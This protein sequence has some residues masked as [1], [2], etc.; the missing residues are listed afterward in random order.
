MSRRLA[1]FAIPVVSLALLARRASPCS[2]TSPPTISGFSPTS[3]PV[4]TLVTIKGTHFGAPGLQ[5]AFGG[6][7]GTPETVSAK[8]IT[9]RVPPLA[10]TGKIQVQTRYGTALSAASFRVTKGL[11]S[12]PPGAWP[13][14]QI[15][16]AGSGLPAFHDVTL[17]LDGSPFGGV[18]TNANGQFSLIR[19][20]PGDLT[21]G[22]EHIL[23]VFDTITQVKLKIRIW[24]F[25]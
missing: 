12:F 6:T 23:A 3:G 22:P 17:K 20:L 25:W 15:T 21:L 1:V 24:I 16:V 19:T 8:Q 14:E 9:I 4:G 2:S 18:A 5:V 11:A 10:P 7:G 13:G